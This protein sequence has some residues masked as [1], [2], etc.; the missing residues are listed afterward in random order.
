MRIGKCLLVALVAGIAY[1]MGAKAGEKRYQQIV[2]AVTKYWNDPAV[3]KARA[4][5]RKARG[6][7][8]KTV[9]R[10]NS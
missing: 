8:A 3:K 7:A 5:A 2:H 6:R 4:K 9:R 1:L 10:L